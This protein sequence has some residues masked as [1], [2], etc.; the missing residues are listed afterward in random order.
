MHP[1]HCCAEQGMQG[2]QARSVCQPRVVH[3]PLHGAFTH[4]P[5]RVGACGASALRTYASALRGERGSCAGSDTSRTVMPSTE[6]MPPATCTHHLALSPSAHQTREK[7]YN[8][9]QLLRPTQLTCA[10]QAQRIQPEAFWVVGGWERRGRLVVTLSLIHIS[11]PTR[12][13]RISYAVFC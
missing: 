1:L 12:L 2:G 7:K 11:E 3:A 8:P 4:N 13:R 10:L 6:I 5:P 9:A